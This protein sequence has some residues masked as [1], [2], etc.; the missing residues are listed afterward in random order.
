VIGIRWTCL[1]D[2]QLS[3]EQLDSIEHLERIG[4]LRGDVS[5]TAADRKGSYSGLIATARAEI[6][7]SGRAA[8]E[9]FIRWDGATRYRRDAA[10]DYPPRLRRGNVRW[11]RG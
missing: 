8:G 4:T 9:V 3:D 2:I 7:V 6:H 11:V 1:E 5:I 10:Y